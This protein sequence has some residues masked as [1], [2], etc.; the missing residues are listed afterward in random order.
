MAV[1][2]QPQPKCNFRVTRER[3]NIL[4]WNAI[5]KSVLLSS[6]LDARLLT[7]MKSKLSKWRDN[8]VYGEHTINQRYHFV[9]TESEMPCLNWMFVYLW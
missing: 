9:P 6:N 2:Y 8:L 5:F 4:F 1:I 7:I 3:S